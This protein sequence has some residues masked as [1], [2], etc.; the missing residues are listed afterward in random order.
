MMACGEWDT[1]TCVTW[2]EWVPA[3]ECIADDPPEEKIEEARE[4]VAL[5]RAPKRLGKPRRMPKEIWKPG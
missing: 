4:C 1:S 3:E 2:Y 5:P